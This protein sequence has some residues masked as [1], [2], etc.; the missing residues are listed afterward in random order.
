MIAALA[1]GLIGSIVAVILGLLT[2]LTPIHSTL[3]GPLTY[4]GPTPIV[5]T[6]PSHPVAR[7]PVT[8]TIAAMPLGVTDLRIAA[9]NATPVRIGPHLWRVRTTAPWIPGPWLLTLDFK[10]HGRVYSTPGTVLEVAAK[11]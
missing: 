9:V 4:N 2:A 7:R 10:L 6:N 8:V 5:V 11:P 3:T 1:H